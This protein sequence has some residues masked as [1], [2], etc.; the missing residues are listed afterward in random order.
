MTQS[1]KNQLVTAHGKQFRPMISKEEI[2]A[3]V[4]EIGASITEKYA[5]KKPLLLSILNGAFM[6]A[7]DLS[8]AID[9]DLELTFIKLASYKGTGSTGKVETVLGLDMDLTNRHII[10]VEDIIDT[11]LTLHNF[12]KALEKESPASVSLCTCFFKKEALQY[13]LS[14]DYVGFEITNKFIIGYGLDY[15]GLG[16]NLPAVYQLNE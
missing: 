16:R 15:D 13:P 11:G 7:A 3:K 6:F 10:I 14:I 9:T 4:A 12:L 5:G 8:R 2:A 1:I